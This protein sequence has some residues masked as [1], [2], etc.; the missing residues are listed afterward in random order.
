MLHNS[1]IAVPVHPEIT[2]ELTWYVTFHC[3]NVSQ[4]SAQSFTGQK[5]KH[6]RS[7]ESLI[8]P[9]VNTLCLSHQEENNTKI[10]NSSALTGTERQAM[11]VVFF[12]CS[13]YISVSYIKTLS[14]AVYL[15]QSS[16]VAKQRYNLRRFPVH[17][18][19]GHFRCG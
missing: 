5:L 8:I 3:Q 9:K 10:R 13:T 2:C 19:T 16:S 12:P 4:V 11:K 18:V 17:S 6:K 1:T 14:L 7:V 15:L